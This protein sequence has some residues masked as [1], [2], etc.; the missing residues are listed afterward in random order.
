MRPLRVLYDNILLEYKTHPAADH[1]RI[2]QHHRV[3]YRG[4]DVRR[5]VPHRRSDDPR[6]RRTSS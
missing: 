3:L 6:G 1:D 2:T 5:G 4:P